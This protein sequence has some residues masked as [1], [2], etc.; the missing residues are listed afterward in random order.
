MAHVTTNELLEAH[1]LHYLVARDF[2][3]VAALA[4][5]HF[6]HGAGNKSR[7]VKCGLGELIVPALLRASIGAVDDDGDSDREAVTAKENKKKEK[8]EKRSRTPPPPPPAAES[9]KKR[10]VN[11]VATAPVETP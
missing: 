9:P 2:K 3:D 8:R 7:L 4:K 11:T 1:I 10:K 6:H 5:T